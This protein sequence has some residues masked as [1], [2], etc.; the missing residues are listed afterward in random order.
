MQERL[1]YVYVR[2]VMISSHAVV[3]RGES[4][5]WFGLHASAFSAATRIV[6]EP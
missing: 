2:I 4:I 6:P 3:Q 1:C 5:V